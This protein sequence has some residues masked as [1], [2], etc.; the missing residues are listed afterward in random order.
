MINQ[1]NLLPKLIEGNKLALI[2][3][4]KLGN[5]DQR[6]R[7]LIAGPYQKEEAT[8]SLIHL[9]LFIYIYQKNR[10]IINFVF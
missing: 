6:D 4:S 2:Q 3:R 10:K 9:L 7:R 5:F 1:Y 8:L